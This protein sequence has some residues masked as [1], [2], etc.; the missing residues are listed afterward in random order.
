MCGL[1]G[2][3]G[4]NACTAD[5]IMLLA[6][7]A[8]IR[9]VD[10][11]GLYSYGKGTF[12]VADRAAVAVYHK[13]FRDYASS[14]LVIG[15]TRMG[16]H[17]AKTVNNAH[18]FMYD[19]KGGGTLAGAHN[20]WIINA[21]DHS[22]KLKIDAKDWDVDS[23]LYFLHLIKTGFNLRAIH[24]DIYAA[25]AL[26]FSINDKLYLY[27]K[28]SKPLFMG[29][30]DDGVYY[31]SRSEGLKLL[32]VKNPIMLFPDI[33]YVFK[34]GV[35]IDEYYYGPSKISLPMDC[36]P[37][38]WR[39]YVSTEEKKAIP[40]E[41]FF[42]GTGQ[43]GDTEAVAS[44]TPKLVDGTGKK[45]TTTDKAE[46]V[47]ILAQ[48]LKEGIVDN[49]PVYK[50]FL[51]EEASR[52]YHK[53]TSR[54][55]ASV[56]FKLKKFQKGGELK[57]FTGIGFTMQR[58]E[59]AFL[60][61]DGLCVVN[62]GK[63]T[64]TETFKFIFADHTHKY[65][66]CSLRIKPEAVVG[67]TATLYPFREVE[68]TS[69]DS[70]GGCGFR[71][72]SECADYAYST[73]SIDCDE[74]GEEGSFAAVE[75]DQWKRLTKAHLGAIL[76]A[77]APQG[78]DPSIAAFRNLNAAISF[79]KQCYEDAGLPT[80]GEAIVRSIMSV[81]E[82]D[83]SRDIN[84]GK[85]QDFILTNID[86]FRNDILEVVDGSIT[87]ENGDFP[88]K[89]N[90]DFADL[91]KNVKDAYD[92]NATLR[93]Q[94]VQLGLAM[95]DPSV[96]WEKLSEFYYEMSSEISDAGLQ[97]E[98][99]ADEMAGCFSVESVYS[100]DSISSTMSGA[101]AACHMIVDAFEDISKKFEK[102]SDGASDGMDAE[103]TFMRE[104]Y[105]KLQALDAESV[106]LLDR[107]RSFILKDLV[108]VSDLPF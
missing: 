70:Q 8:Q 103:R 12:K 19:L 94:M 93:S 10:S 55:H 34:D 81:M 35:M 13:E 99:I 74:D 20:G 4:P 86:N 16:T 42:R 54:G 97:Y 108:S 53:P 85:A 30:H 58:P 106:A 90:G 57:D 76:S 82:D 69:S 72:G 98:V 105:E 101:L 14:S 45:T 56:I 62:L 41:D 1:Y 25:A 67:V 107:L 88:Y 37:S 59:D 80:T 18:P 87:E 49:D 71:N 32:G 61:T 38:Q 39:S 28:T 43:S 104:Y 48:K 96:D 17:G 78:I 33:F 73:R 29:Q 46:G 50:E 89:I 3:S 75:G 79:I 44:T 102:R 11:T 100:D 5:K 83:A 22:K 91:Y 68:K 23:Q 26:S 95:R 47:L 51:Y 2:F 9:G 65:F 77:P 64:K 31:S 60:I 36:L 52:V 27:R 40:G 63:L 92:A 15:H 24:E 66:S 6:L 21:N 84:I 7:D